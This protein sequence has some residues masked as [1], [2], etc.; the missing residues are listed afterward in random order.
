VR[1]IP[2]NKD[3]EFVVGEDK[4][5][6]FFLAF[7]FIAL[8]LYGLIDSIRQGITKLTLNAIFIFALVPA[9]LFVA[10]AKRK[11]VYIRINKTGIYQDEQLV[12]GWSNFLNAY[13]SQKEVKWI[14]IKDNFILVV[15]YLKEG[16]EKGFRRKIPL[17]NTQNKSEEQVLEA[18]K[19]F[20]NEYSVANSQKK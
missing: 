4:V 15:E 19:F 10:K 6:N 12:T 17:T 20:W 14:S 11:R 7:L 3:Q 8:F 18:V 1:N 2:L 13:I 16:S 9:G 5:L